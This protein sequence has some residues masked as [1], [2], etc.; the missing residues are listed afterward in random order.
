M[1]TSQRLLHILISVLVSVLGWLGK[2][3]YETTRILDSRLTTVEATII[4]RTEVLQRL[5]VM[6]AEI[7]NLKKTL[8]ND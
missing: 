6:E 4:D 1:Q 5:S 3:V 2:N 7:E 8:E